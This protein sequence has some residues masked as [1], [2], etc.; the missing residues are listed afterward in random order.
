V[1]GEKAPV[2]TTAPAQAAPKPEDKKQGQTQQPAQ[3]TPAEK[4][5]AAT[6]PIKKK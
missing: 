3:K 1:G 5:A 4:P 6:A 2:E